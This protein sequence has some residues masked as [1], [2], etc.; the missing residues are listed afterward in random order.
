MLATESFFKTD[1]VLSRK[2]H[3]ERKE[4]KDGNEANVASGITQFAEGEP[5]RR[6][7]DTVSVNQPL[8]GG[9]GKENNLPLEPRSG[10]IFLAVGE[11]HGKLCS[12]CEI[13]HCVSRKPPLDVGKSPYLQL[14]GEAV[15][16]C[17]SLQK[18]LER[19]NP[20]DPLVRG[21]VV[22]RRQILYSRCCLNL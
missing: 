11:T 5:K 4:M 14:D 15:K 21:R 18:S 8:K 1:E 13:P 9:N 17:G 2:E 16:K 19:V 20:S 6:K 12:K 22:R 7:Y 3:K 10:S